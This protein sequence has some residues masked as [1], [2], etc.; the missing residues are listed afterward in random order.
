M[1]H[2][3]VLDGFLLKLTGKWEIFVSIT[4]AQIVNLN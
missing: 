3:V 2:S 1:I 4:A